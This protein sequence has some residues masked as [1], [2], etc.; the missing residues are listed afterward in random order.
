MLDGL[1]HVLQH[2]LMGVAICDYV[3]HVDDYGQW[4]ATWLAIQNTLYYEMESS[5]HLY[6][7]HWHPKPLEVIPVCN[8]G[9]V[10]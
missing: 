10:I 2:L 1:K 9:Q 4:A 7:A 3:V 5:R 8:E 6:Q